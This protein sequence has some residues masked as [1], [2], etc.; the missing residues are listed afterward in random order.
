MA[1]TTQTADNGVVLITGATSGIGMACSYKLAAE[2]YGVVLLG[3]RSDR[4]KEAAE[5]IKSR[6][7]A[8]RVWT[9]VCDVQDVAQVQ[10]LSKQEWFSQITAVINNAGLALGADRV[11]DADP[12]D[13]DVM[14]QTNVMGLLYVTRLVLPQL[15]QSGRGHVLNIGSVA[16][17]WVYAGGAVYCASKF[18]VRAISE[19]LRLDL[20]GRKVR[21]TNVEPGMV[22]SEFSMVRFGDEA[23][24]K[25][26]YEGMRP[27]KPEDIADTVHWCLARPSHV[28]IQ[29]LVI[30]PTDQAAVGVV[31]RR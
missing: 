17:R 14:I 28:N 23:K 20:A 1:Q 12:A 3:R 6:F 26:V 31:D 18:A 5:G 16:G 27:L 8:A 2:G 21:V 9:S 7:K 24:A 15:I 19:G 29:E 4:L 11:Q 30:Y 13:W 22:E 25:K 10:A